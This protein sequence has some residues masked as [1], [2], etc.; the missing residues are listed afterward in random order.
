[1]AS[2]PDI[3]LGE[4][5][6]L[7]Q[8]LERQHLVPLWEIAPRLL[9][10]E[11]QP[12]ATPHL[13]RWADIAPLAPRR[14]C[15]TTSGNAPRKRCGSWPPLVPALST[16]WHW[17]ISIRI[18][19]GRCC[20]LWRVG[21]SS[22]GQACT[23]RRIGRRIAPSI[24]FSRERVIQ[25]LTASALPGKPATSSS[26]HCGLGMSMRMIP[27]RMPSCFRCKILPSSTPS[28]CIANRPLKLTTAI[29]PSS[30]YF[31]RRSPPCSSLTPATH[32]ADSTPLQFPRALHL[33]LAQYSS[34]PSN[35]QD[36]RAD[37]S[38]SPRHACCE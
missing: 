36:G 38:L 27:M 25:S 17:S 34:R 31:V 32:V 20:R 23:P 14:L 15:S 1:M 9:P 22:F 18:L 21:S 13:W 19:A 6:E 8:D 24:T 11:P 30:G 28:A 29:K 37:P 3:A 35:P 4:L 26:C 2:T 12:Q 33:P 10:R 7:Y 5:P 16:M